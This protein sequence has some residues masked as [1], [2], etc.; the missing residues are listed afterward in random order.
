[1][2][3]LSWEELESLV[4]P[5][6]DRINGP[7]NSQAVLRLFGRSENEV[8]VVLYRDHHGWCPYCQKI[9]LWLEFKRIPYRIRKVTMRC[10]GPKEPWFLEKVP[11]GML[12]ALELNGRLIT[13]SDDILLALEQQFGPLGMA[14]T[15]P[16]ALELR[17]LERLLFQAWCIWLCSPRLSPRQQVLAREQF[18]GIAQRFERELN[19]EE[20]PWLR[21]PEPQT[22]DLVFVPYV[23]RMNASLAYYKGYRLRAEHPAIDRWFRALERLDTYRGTQSDFHTHAH[24]LPPQ[25]GGCWSDDGEDAQHLATQIDRGDGLGEDEACWDG[26]NQADQAAIALSRVLRHQ[27]RLREVNP[28]GAE[29]FDQPPA[30]CP[31]PV[32]PQH[33][34]PAFSGECHRAPPPARSHFGSQGHAPPGGATAASGPRSHRT[35]GWT[36]ASQTSAG[37]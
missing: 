10:Y 4:P 5:P 29:A 11:S 24:D 30:L 15:A 36:E 8:Q 14:M 37:A 26:V 27:Q 31:H 33:T 9:W 32:D 6:I 13:E 3:A 18:Q 17:R 7:T 34:L 21:G 19:R 28:M 23:E 2:E 20:G 35:A 1:M 22:V 16:E 12:P 25:M